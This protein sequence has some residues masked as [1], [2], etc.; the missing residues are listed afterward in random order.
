MVEYGIGVDMAHAFLAVRGIRLPT[1]TRY[2]GGLPSPD[3]IACMCGDDSNHSPGAF[4]CLC[5]LQLGCILYI[6]SES[7]FSFYIKH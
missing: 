4:I 6:C 3:S 5:L 2:F 7:E 1:P